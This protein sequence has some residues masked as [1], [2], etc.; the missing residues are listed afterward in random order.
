MGISADF[1]Y[2]DGTI[3]QARQH[4]DLVFTVEITDSNGDALSTTLYSDA[5]YVIA[6][7]EGKVLITKRLG[8]GIAALAEA[9]QVYVSSAELSFEGACE[10]Q[11]V[12]TDLNNFRLPPVFLQPLIILPTY[13]GA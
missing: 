6:D 9:F 2:H 3:T 13:K 12:V 1:T 11:L 4:S 7:A 10:H 5:E 8:D